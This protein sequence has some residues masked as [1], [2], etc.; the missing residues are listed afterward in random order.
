MKTNPYLPHLLTL[1]LVGTDSY[2]HTWTRFSQDL[3]LKLH[4]LSKEKCCF[5]IESVVIM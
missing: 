2:F 1:Y 5:T 4:I 3:D